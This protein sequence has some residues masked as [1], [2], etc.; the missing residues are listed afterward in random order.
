MSAAADRL[1]LHGGDL[2]GADNMPY[3]VTVMSATGQVTYQSDCAAAEWLEL[4]DGDR[5][6]VANLSSCAGAVAA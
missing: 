1:E 4:A 2:S 6:G 5:F 3:V